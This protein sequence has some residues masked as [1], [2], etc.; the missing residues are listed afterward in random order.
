MKKKNYRVFCKMVES[1]LKLNID[2]KLKSQNF[3]P[4]DYH[5][6]L[7]KYTEQVI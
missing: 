6:L 4:D 7:A 1:T 3:S 5:F 2:K